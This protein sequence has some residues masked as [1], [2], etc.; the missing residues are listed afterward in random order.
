MTVDVEEH[1]HASVFDEVVTRADW[2][3]LESRVCGNTGRLLDALDRGGVKASF[4]VLGCVA[5]RHPDLV[6]EISSR[7]HEVA[8]HGFGHELIYKQ[9]PDAFREDVR[10]S[11]GVLEDLAGLEVQG[12]RAPSYSITARSLWALDILVEEGYRYDSSVFPI[13]HDRYG[14]PGAPREVYRI[15]L[16]AGTLIEAPPATVTIGGVNLPVSGGGYF[17]LLPYAWTR[18]GLSRV[19]A[20]GRPAV[21]YLHPWEID[22]EQPRLGLKGISRV[23]HYRNLHLTA[24]RLG[25]LLRDFTFVPLRALLA[26]MLDNRELAPSIPFQHV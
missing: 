3:R 5:D 10:R 2:D 23:R 20:E 22:P 8:S 17:R 1:F 21:F 15:D 4:F 24:S 16:P 11:K 14:I 13:H 25:R 9:S 26:D 6:R 7:G 19:N 18:W 12:F